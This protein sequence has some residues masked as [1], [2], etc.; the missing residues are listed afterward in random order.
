MNGPVMIDDDNGPVMQRERE[1]ED[2]KNIQSGVVRIG[3]DQGQ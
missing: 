2:A 1:R 3:N